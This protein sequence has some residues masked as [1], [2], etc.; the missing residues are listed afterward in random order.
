MVHGTGLSQL[1]LVRGDWMGVP[2]NTRSARQDPSASSC[3]GSWLFLGSGMTPTR[4][5]WLCISQGGSSVRT[6]D[7]AEELCVADVGDA[8]LA[9]KQR[10]M[11]ALKLGRDR[12]GTVF[13]VPS[14]LG[15]TLCAYVSLKYVVFFSIVLS[16]LPIRDVSE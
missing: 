15:Q 16:L 13:Y 1:P 11:K 12:S 10:L 7:T 8:R 9:S 5:S 3:V 2:A 6:S 14:T 4:C